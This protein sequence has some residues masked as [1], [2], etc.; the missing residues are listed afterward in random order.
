MKETILE[1]HLDDPNDHE[2]LI[3]VEI[4][5]SDINQDLSKP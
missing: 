4:T 5:Q 2:N 1:T 3:E